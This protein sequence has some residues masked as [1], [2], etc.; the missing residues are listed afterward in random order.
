MT[1]FMLDLVNTL[2]SATTTLDKDFVARNVEVRLSRRNSLLGLDKL[3]LKKLNLNLYND[4]KKVLVLNPKL[5]LPFLKKEQSVN[6]TKK[7]RFIIEFLEESIFYR[8]LENEP[9]IT[10][11]Q[12]AKINAMNFS[13]EMDT[14]NSRIVYL[15]EIL[16]MIYANKN[17]FYLDI[18]GFGGYSRI[19]DLLRNV[20]DKYYI[21]ENNIKF[22]LLDE[23]EKNHILKLIEFYDSTEELREVYPLKIEFLNLSSGEL[24]FIKHFSNLNKAIHI[25]SLNKR[26]KNMIIFLDEPDSNFHPEWSRRYISNLVNLLNKIALDRNFKFQVI[27]TTH[28]PF[29][30]SDIP[31][32]FITCIDVVKE[33]GELKRV[34]SKADFGF[35]SNFYDLIKNN[36]FMKYPIGDYARSIF[37]NLITD[38]DKLDNNKDQIRKIKNIISLIDDPLIKRKLLNYIEQKID[39]IGLSDYEKLIIEKQKLEKQ[40]KEIEEKLNI[41]RKDQ[42]LD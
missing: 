13:K 14:F 21:N 39:A 10:S 9:D 18:E 26:I 36:F 5:K 1:P 4:D 33:H 23:I 3:A 2:K 15:N 6:W 11:R 20:E 32:Q 35:M 34:V 27:M 7:E 31:K 19:I 17:V 22:K 30:I 24:Q 12:V 38:I 37:K 16:Q 40:Q 42:N 25:A 28:S 8:L 41:I 29:M